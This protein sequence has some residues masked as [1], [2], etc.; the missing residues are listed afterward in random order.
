SSWMTGK[1]SWSNG[2]T[3]ARAPG[4]PCQ[5]G[6]SCQASA[7]ALLTEDS[8]H[9]EEPRAGTT[10]G[11]GDA[12]GLRD[13]F[14]RP[15][16]RLHP[17]LEGCFQ[18]LWIEVMLCSEPLAHRRELG[19]GVG[20]QELLTGLFVELGGLPEVKVQVMRCVPIGACPLPD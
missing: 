4:R 3:S 12:G 18:G 2:A 13:V 16:L 20:N 7:R 8:D 10:P 9:V 17:T 6:S 19:C 5:L 15:A 11:Q 14:E 1:V